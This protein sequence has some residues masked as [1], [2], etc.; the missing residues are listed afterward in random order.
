M[1]ILISFTL[2]VSFVEISNAQSLN[3]S[4]NAYF[5]RCLDDYFSQIQ[6]KQK[7]TV[8]VFYSE[9]PVSL[10]KTFNTGG[11]GYALKAEKV[12][13]SNLSDSTTLKK[14]I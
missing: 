7:D 9:Q 3:D 10:N 12:N 11:S 6:E 5:Q 14:N 13:N 2:I 4:T 1:K 8:L